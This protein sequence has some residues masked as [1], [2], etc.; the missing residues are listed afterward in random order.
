MAEQLTAVLVVEDDPYARDH[1]GV[2]ISKDERTR[3][4]GAYA[5]IEE[6]E[7]ALGAT[8][9]GPWPDVMLIDVRLGSAERAGI[10]GI[11]ALRAHSPD[12]KVLMTSTERD[13]ETVLAAIHAGADGY[14]W[15]AE[16]GS[17]I[18]DAVMRVAEGRFVVTR[19]VAERILGKTM[20]LRDYATEILP[21][22][23]SCQDLTEALRKTVYLYCI[24]GM[25]AKEIADELQV[26]VN[27]VNSRIKVAYQV[28][29]ATSRKEAFQ[30]LVEREAP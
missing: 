25:S 4:W 22:D 9:K 26:S 29:Q 7:K 2:F 18:V 21:D 27:T 19:S 15:K 17:G 12:S 16:T 30:R 28:L 6:A 13:E 23:H 20:E 14:V 1:I 24:C 11:A 5:S 3:L 8:G 10:E